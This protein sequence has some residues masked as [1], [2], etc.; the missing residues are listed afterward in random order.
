ME[1]KITPNLWFDM[2][3]AEEAAEFYVSIFENSKVTAI[4]RYPE[5][6][7]GPA[8]EVM[9][10]EFELDG[11][12]FIAINGGP[13]F[14]FSEAVSFM[15]TCEDQAEIDYFWEKLTD[16]GEESQCGWLRDRFGVAW[17]IV[18]RGMDDVFDDDD[19]ARAQRAFA[20]MMPMKKL[21]VEVL[22]AAAA[23]ES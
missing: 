3:K 5:G 13:Q 17:Q 2:G 20:A 23:G 21:D 8:G 7:P 1:L 18:P 9:T 12:P 19:P 14:S 6:S 16:G 22:R 10:V 11:V 15:V 4:R